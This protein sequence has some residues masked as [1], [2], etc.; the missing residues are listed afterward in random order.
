MHYVENEGVYV[1]LI[2]ITA[3]EAAYNSLRNNWIAEIKDPLEI[4]KEVTFGNSRIDLFC[5]S[6]GLKTYI[7][8]KGVTLIKDGYLQFPDAPTI[9]GSKHL[10]ELIKIKKTG[11]RAVVL[12]VAQHLLGDKFK[13][14][15]EAD[16]LF[17]ETFKRAI[18][19]GVE[20]YA[21]S[22][23]DSIGIYELDKKIKLIKE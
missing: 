23:K 17:Y 15:R 1:N 4:K 20:A 21:Y 3:N 6:Q 11:H 18:N 13:I 8:V 19:E 5:L 14:N 9:R 2:S 22:T 7:E 12:F 10:E 16:K